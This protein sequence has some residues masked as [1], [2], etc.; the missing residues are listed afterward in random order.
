[1]SPPVLLRPV[2]QF[3]VAAQCQRMQA[4]A[5]WADGYLSVRR[6][7]PSPGWVAAAGMALSVDGTRALP[8]VYPVASFPLGNF[9]RTFFRDLKPTPDD[10]QLPHAGQGRVL[11]CPSIRSPGTFLPVVFTER[12]PLF[13]SFAMDAIQAA[14]QA[15][16]AAPEDAASTMRYFEHVRAWMSYPEECIQLALQA[17]RSEWLQQLTNPFEI[18]FRALGDDSGLDDDDESDANSAIGP[19]EAREMLLSAMAQ[20]QSDPVFLH[21]AHI[22]D[23]FTADVLAAVADVDQFP[24]HFCGVDFAVARWLLGPDAMTGAMHEG[25]PTIFGALRAADGRA[26]PITAAVVTALIHHFGRIPTTGEDHARAVEFV[27]KC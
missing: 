12:T 21:V 26:I 8:T 4:V 25:V 14:F 22:Q 1:M 2:N 19:D 27:A 3:Q 5:A 9:H 15:C 18:F 6:V 16:E 11:Q 10:H 20:A 24:V 13:G 7:T 23:R 17:A